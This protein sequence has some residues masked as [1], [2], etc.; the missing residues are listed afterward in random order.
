METRG[1]GMIAISSNDGGDLDRLVN[2]M[3]SDACQAEAPH[4]AF[5]EQ[6]SVGFPD[7]SNGAC[8]REA[9]HRR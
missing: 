5:H 4:L 8:C 7:A 1:S 9:R 6:V 2:M 3:D